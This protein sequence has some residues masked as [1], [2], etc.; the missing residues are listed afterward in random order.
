MGRCGNCADGCN[1]K[2]DPC[3]VAPEGAVLGNLEVNYNIV[4]SEKTSPLND[5]VIRLNVVNVSSNTGGRDVLFIH[6][7][8]HAW[9]LW[10]NQLAN[11]QLAQNHNLYA[12]DVRG[13]GQSE[14]PGFGTFAGCSFSNT[15]NYDVLATDIYNVIVELNLVRPVVVVHSLGGPILANFLRKYGDTSA[16]GVGGACG[17]VSTPNG[18]GLS[19]IVLTNSFPASDPAYFTPETIDLIQSGDFFTEELGR[20]IPAV[21]KFAELSS[22]CRL[23]RSDF[24]DVVQMDMSNSVE[25]RTGILSIVPPPDG[26][27]PVWQ[28][29]TVPTLIIEGLEDNVINPLGSET[30]EELIPDAKLKR[31]HCVGH[32]PQMEAFRKYNRTLLEFLNSLPPL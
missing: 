9:P 16:G 1:D 11:S 30:L 20:L 4:L 5:Q 18:P 10:K 27:V 24:A 6:G 14:N 22:F 21:K 29:V 26:N 2:C 8:P 32:L 3:C 31:F 12:M 7:F 25:S 17:V 23:H 13:F 15:W 28:S 19:G